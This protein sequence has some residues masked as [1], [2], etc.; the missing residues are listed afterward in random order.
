MDAPASGVLRW[1][2]PVYIVLAIL[3][4]AMFILSLVQVWVLLTVPDPD[5]FGSIQATNA[6][7]PSEDKRGAFL[8]LNPAHSSTYAGDLVQ[9]LAT[10][11]A[12]V[13]DATQGA[14]LKAKD[15]KE[16]LVQSANVSMETKDYR[17]TVIG[18]PADYPM[19][20]TREPGGKVLRIRPQNGAWKPGAYLVDI[21]SEGMFG[22]RDYF[23]FYIDPDTKAP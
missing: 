21:P 6:G 16:I 13:I 17:I 20:Y 18:D 4:L 12:G 8:S 14:H 1:R 9:L 7:L 3:A 10:T 22:G 23:Q 15:L 19:S 2:K 11:E 5:A